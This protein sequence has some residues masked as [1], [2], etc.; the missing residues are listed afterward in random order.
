[1]FELVEDP[2]YIA[3]I[4]MIGVGGAG[5]NTINYA[6]NYGIHGVECI[7]VNTDAQVLKLNKASEK[8]QVGTNLTQGLGA[9]GDPEIGRKAAEESRE[10]IR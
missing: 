7:A 8:I 6:T 5:C 4:K 3:K 2:K 10:K 9:G 1:M